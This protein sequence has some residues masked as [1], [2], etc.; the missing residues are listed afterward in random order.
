MESKT[1]QAQTRAKSADL[2]IRQDRPGWFSL[3]AITQAGRQFAC[4][5]P[6]SYQSVEAG[7]IVAS[8]QSR[9]L[10]VKG[11]AQIARPCRNGVN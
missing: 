11:T 10:S 1:R 4:Q 7:R 6:Y 2:S 3:E 8:A 5:R 9:G